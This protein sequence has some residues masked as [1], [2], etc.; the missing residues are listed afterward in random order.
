MTSLRKKM[1]LLIFLIVIL[2]MLIHHIFTQINIPFMFTNTQSPSISTNLIQIGNVE[3]SRVLENSGTTFVYIGRPTCP[4][5]AELEPVLNDV[6]YELDQTIYYFNTDEAYQ[7]DAD[8]MA[9]L[10]DPL[11]V[12]SV[13]AIIYIVDGELIDK[14]QGLQTFEDLQLF[15]TKYLENELEVMHNASS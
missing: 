6:L 7:E 14:L 15:F 5:C 13:P 1:Y 9:S 2:V 11:E 3:L 8:I 4:V 12:M 10:L